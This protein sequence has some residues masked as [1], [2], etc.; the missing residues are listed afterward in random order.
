VN[1]DLSLGRQDRRCRA[2]TL[3][4]WRPLRGESTGFALGLPMVGTKVLDRDQRERQP[5]GYTHHE[6]IA[7]R[8]G[9]P[10]GRLFY[11]FQRKSALHPWYDQS[12]IGF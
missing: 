1:R 4:G 7:T 2:G 10:A 3:R 11:L 9:C 6:V 5:K 8:A 12:L